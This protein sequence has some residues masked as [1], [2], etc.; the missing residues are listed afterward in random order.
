MRSNAESR[1]SEGR[2]EKHGGRLYCARHT[3]EPNTI[4]REEE[5]L[6]QAIGEAYVR[7]SALNPRRAATQTHRTQAGGV[8]DARRVDHVLSM[9]DASR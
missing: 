5:N 7:T 3:K 8:H 4:R 9:K 2:G 6:G 1:K